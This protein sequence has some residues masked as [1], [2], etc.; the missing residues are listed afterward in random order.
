MK[1]ITKWEYKSF[2]E[3]H[4]GVQEMLDKYSK[5]GWKVIHTHINNEVSFDTDL[6]RVYWYILME[7]K[8]ED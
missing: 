5:E 2:C 7:R 1:Q 8:I 3:D 4:C 6:N